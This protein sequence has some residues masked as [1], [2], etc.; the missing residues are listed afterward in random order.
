MKRYY[1]TKGSAER[2]RQLRKRSHITQSMLAEQAN[3]SVDT[4]KRLERGNEGSV[5]VLLAIASKLNLMSITLMEYFYKCI[6]IKKHTLLRC[7]LYN[8]TLEI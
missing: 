3:I 5:N 8:K 1:N 4:V 7:V 2:I 6:H